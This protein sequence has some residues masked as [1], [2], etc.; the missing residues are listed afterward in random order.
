MN[1]FFYTKNL[2]ALALVGSA[3]F[4]ILFSFWWKSE[5]LDMFRLIGAI[6]FSSIGAIFFKD[7]LSNKDKV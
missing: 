7:V 1:Y 6:T 4:G 5:D 2:L 3:L